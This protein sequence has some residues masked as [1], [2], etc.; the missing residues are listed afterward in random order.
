MQDVTYKSLIG[1]LWLAWVAYW[2]IAAAGAKK[3][4]R[5]ESVSSRLTHIAPLAIAVLLIISPHQANILFAR[6]LPRS[7]FVDLAGLALVAAGLAFAVWARLHLGHNW[8]GT[9]TLKHDHEL[10]R[11]GPYA[12]VRNP[13]YTGL[14]VAFLGTALSLGEWRGLAALAL[15]AIAFVRKIAIEEDFLS[16]VFGAAFARYRTE[17]PA[18]IPFV[19]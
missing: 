11:T 16:G 14:L 9:V 19:W 8:S 10:I 18:L 2:M 13:I 1:L 12:L 7:A 15:A 4:A 6:L 5:R 3:T 17:V